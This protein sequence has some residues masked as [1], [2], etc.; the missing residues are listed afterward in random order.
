M[1]FRFRLETSLRL[2]RQELEKAQCLLA[3]ELRKLYKAYEFRDNQLDAFHR[4]LEGQKKACLHEPYN[5]RFWQEYT[6][7]QKRK[8]EEYEEFVKKQEKVVQ[9]YREEL[10]QFRIK[11]E[12]LKRLKEKKWKLYC[13]EQLKK[14]QAVIDEI[15][16]RCTYGETV[17]NNY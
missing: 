10:K 6:Q 9:G 4:A 8:L 14:E 13:L 12:K 2:A 17:S 1:V 7:R 15:A 16:Q 3:N 11:L 5:L